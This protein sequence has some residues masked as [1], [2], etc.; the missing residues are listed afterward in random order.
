MEAILQILQWII[1]SGGLGVV[2]GWFLNRRV[3]QARSKKDIH[4]TFKQMYEDVSVLLLA[5]QKKNEELNEQ[6]NELKEE[7]ARTRRTTNRL[8]RAIEAIP[9]C[10][11]H[12][13]CPV[14]SELRLDEDG[15][16]RGS[17][18]ADDDGRR[19]GRKPG[20][21]GS[22]HPHAGKRGTVR[23][24][25]VAGVASGR[26]RVQQPGGKHR[27]V[28]QQGEGRQ[29]EDPCDDHAESRP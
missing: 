14:L 25:G 29:S 20:T 26:G 6:I 2:G 27:R 5:M 4:D 1:P 23:S 3:S 7:N 16:P 12:S 11:Y 21:G 8:T 10:D 15:S 9:L 24:A 19:D 13:Q 17:E 28:G 22:R 18:K